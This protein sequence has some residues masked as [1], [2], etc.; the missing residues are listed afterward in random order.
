[1]ACGSN[2]LSLAP[3]I[4]TPWWGRASW[5]QEYVVEAAHVK[6]DKKQRERK[7]IGTGHN[8]HR[9]TS[10]TLLPLGRPHSLF[11]FFIVL[12]FI[13]HTRLG[14][15][16]PPAPTPSLTTHSTPS[17]SPHPLNTQQE[18]FCPYL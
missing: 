10:N 7:E 1:L 3:L 9:P 5:Q 6:V 15:F 8:L 4:L 18:L 12:L 13:V 17:L 14:S 11:C 2:P 16:L